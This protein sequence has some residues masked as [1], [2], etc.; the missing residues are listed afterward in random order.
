MPH[1]STFIL[2]DCQ[3]LLNR[4]PFKSTKASSS[5]SLGTPYD[6]NVVSVRKKLHAFL[7]KVSLQSTSASTQNILHD[8]VEEVAW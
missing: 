5:I 2:I 8:N 3:N 7:K 6:V 4:L 1:I